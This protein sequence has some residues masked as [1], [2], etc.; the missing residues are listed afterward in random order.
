LHPWFVTGLIDGNGCFKIKI[1]SN[2]PPCIKK[3]KLTSKLTSNLSWVVQVR[4]VINVH[5]KD[6]ALLYKVKSF[7]GEIGTIT[8]NSKRAR[9]SIVSFKDIIRCVLP[10]FSDYPLHSVKIIDYLV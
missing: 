5:I 4:F 6:L 7:F 10:H 9:Y 3:S 8:T 1:N 2:L